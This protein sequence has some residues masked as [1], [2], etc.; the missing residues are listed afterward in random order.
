MGKVLKLSNET[1]QRLV[2]LAHQQQ[3]TPEEMISS[4]SS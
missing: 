4:L 3:R 1:Y 2:D